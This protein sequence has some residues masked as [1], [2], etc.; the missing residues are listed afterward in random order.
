MSLTTRLTPGTCGAPSRLKLGFLLH[1]TTR[2]Q[3]VLPYLRKLGKLEMLLTLVWLFICPR[4]IRVR[5]V[6]RAVLEHDWCGIGTQTCDRQGDLYCAPIPGVPVYK[7]VCDE[8]G[9]EVQFAYLW[10]NH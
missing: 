8:D 3:G 9:V 2:N 10:K 4:D 1:L 5:E 7:L 6:W